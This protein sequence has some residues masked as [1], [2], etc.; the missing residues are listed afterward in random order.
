MANLEEHVKIGHMNLPDLS[1]RACHWKSSEL[2]ALVN[3]VLKEHTKVCLKCKTVLPSQNELE[4]HRKKKHELFKCA[5]CEF[6][7]DLAS[8]LVSHVEACRS[9]H[10]KPGGSQGSGQNGIQID[11]N[12]YESPSC[13][14]YP[15]AG[16]QGSVGHGKSGS[17]QGSG[18]N[19]NQTNENDEEKPLPQNS[20]LSEKPGAGNAGSVGHGKSGGS[21]G[22]GQNG[23]QTN[24]NIYESLPLPGNPGNEDAISPGHPGGN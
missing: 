10:G 5:L 13:T 20:S 16:S 8:T 17:S 4:K 7:T 22:S 11:E 14:E 6:T 19:G 24:E 3:H 2:P 21:Q 23:S 1:C 12:I 18:H 15:G 9:L